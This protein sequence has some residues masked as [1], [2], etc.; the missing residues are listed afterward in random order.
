MTPLLSRLGIIPCF[1]TLAKAIICSLASSNLPVQMKRPRAEMKT[2][3]PQHLAHL[4]EKCGSPAA[5]HGT[6]SVG[7]KEAD[8]TYP[9]CWTLTMARLCK[10]FCPF[11]MLLL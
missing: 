6:L 4:T 2:S 8:L 7:H 10:N 1:K 3:R 9:V 11:W 5:R